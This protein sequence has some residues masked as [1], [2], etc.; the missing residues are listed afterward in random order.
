MEQSKIL[1]L[2]EK[3]KSY[4]SFIRLNML[5]IDRCVFPFPTINIR[6]QTSS[7]HYLSSANAIQ[8]H[9]DHYY[10]FLRILFYLS[11]IHNSI[12]IQP[13]FINICHVIFL[14]KILSRYHYCYFF[15]ERSCFLQGS[16]YVHFESGNPK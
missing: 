6:I 14:N 12:K 5:A 9:T 4:G 10:T 11:E 2:G 7:T 8:L 15:I 1:S 3:L 16:R 13:V